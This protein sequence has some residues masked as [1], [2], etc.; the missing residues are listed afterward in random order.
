M[1]EMP[2]KVKGESEE[3]LADCNVDLTLPKGWEREQG[4]I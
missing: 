4:H 3:R 1:E 2:V